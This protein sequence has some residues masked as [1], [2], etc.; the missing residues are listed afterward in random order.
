MVV[1]RHPLKRMKSSLSL[2]KL[3]L[4]LATALIVNNQNYIVEPSLSVLE[5][6]KLSK[7]QHMSRITGDEGHWIRRFLSIS[8]IASST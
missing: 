4:S 8:M 6:L 7:V 2:G 1:D 5:S 3:G